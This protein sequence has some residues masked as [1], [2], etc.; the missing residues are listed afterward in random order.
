MNP[1]T[2]PAVLQ[3]KALLEEA[4][5]N[6]D[7]TQ[8]LTGRGAATKEEAQRREAALRV[9]E[10]KHEAALNVVQEQLAMLA[11]RKAELSIAEQQ[12]ANAVVKAPF[13]GIIQ[14]RHVAPGSYVSIGQPVVTLVRT[15][16]LRFRAG[17]PER[18]AMG[19]RGGQMVRIFLEGEPSPV[20]ARITRISPAL[21]TRNRALIIEA[22]V[23]NSAGRL[24][25]GLF[26]EAEI[27]VDP[28]RRVLA[29][30]VSSIVAFGG[31]EKVWVVQDQK[32]HSQRVLTGRRMGDYVEIVEGLE[33]GAVIVRDGR[34]GREGLVQVQPEQ[35]ARPN[36]ASKEV[37]GE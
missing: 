1:A 15:S 22:D 36:V 32:A 17:V 13:A 11:V 19:V 14:E 20:E 24:I 6:L 12:R 34:K 28:E 35:S 4:K 16:P 9:A 3:E 8:R 5:F 10:A 7:L 18:S 27:V 21:D 25:A 31:V 23:D 33:P 37:I 26:A 2:A 29:A 30:P